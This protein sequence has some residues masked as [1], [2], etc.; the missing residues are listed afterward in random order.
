MVSHDHATIVENAKGCEI[1]PDVVP[2][3][4]GGVKIALA[5]VGEGVG[6]HVF[7]VAA[8]VVDGVNVGPFRGLVSDVED[9][10]IQLAVG[11]ELPF[12]NL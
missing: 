5:N 8:Y 9:E 6:G 7:G 4:R 12:L 10:Q 11:L 1:E 2:S 3:T